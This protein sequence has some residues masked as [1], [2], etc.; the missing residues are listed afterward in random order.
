[1]REF[2]RMTVVLTVFAIGAG[3]FLAGTYQLTKDRIAK[4]QRN[5]LLAGLKRVL[6]ECENDVVA[7]AVNVKDG[8][9]AWT[10]YPA[11]KKGTLLAVAFETE[12]DK[13]YG[14]PIRVLVSVLADN[15]ISRVE[16]LQA[17]KETP[18]LGSKINEPSFTANFKG[19]SVTDT[20]LI[21]VQKDGGAVPHITGAT[22]SSRAVCHAIKTGLEVLN[23]H[24]DEI[25]AARG[26]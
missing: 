25:A 6:P 2:V 26:K 10:F 4:E 11:R 17:D 1:M 19:R 23:K 16:I 8:N 5:E 15:T 21:A 24:R 13:G 9:N 12:S 3:L 7:D 20:G 14:G 18:G 22:I